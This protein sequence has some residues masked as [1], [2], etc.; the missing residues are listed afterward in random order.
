LFLKNLI[1]PLSKY[2][3]L[4]ISIL[5]VFLS[6]LS[7]K[8]ILDTPP[9]PSEQKSVVLF[10]NQ[11]HPTLKSTVYDAIDSAKHEIIIS[12]FGLIERELIE[13]LEKK[14]AEGI[15]VEVHFCAKTVDNFPY[16]GGNIRVIG[17][18]GDG[19]MHQKIIAIDGT[20]IYLGSTNLSFNSYKVHDNLII[21]FHSPSFTQ[22]VLE[23]LMQ[24]SYPLTIEECF[25]D[26]RV[27][28]WSLPGQKKAAL[29]TLI[30]HINAARQKIECQIFTFTHP[31]I[32]DA[33]CAA[34]QRGVDVEVNI[35]KKSVK[36]ASKESI[37]NLRVKGARIFTNNHKGLLH[38][39]MMLIDEKKFFFGSANWTRSAFEKNR[40]YLILI[41]DIS[42]TLSQEITAL[43]KAASGFKKPYRVD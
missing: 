34:I 23:Q 13:K 12:T 43:F 3:G 14:D 9:L 32:V 31:K 35:D 42:P 10:S 29:R 16:L 27:K 37:E 6:L 36:G 17:H 15:K 5:F 33:L 1:N 24:P 19:L 41:E 18:R 8:N 11:I 2:R 22:K 7:L 28:F 26:A 38:H 20:C 39:K 25:E 30:E 4:N 21:G 40:D